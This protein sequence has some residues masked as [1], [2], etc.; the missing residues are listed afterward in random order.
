M[1]A[2]DYQEERRKHYLS[3]TLNINKKLTQTEL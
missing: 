3:L 1:H 2:E